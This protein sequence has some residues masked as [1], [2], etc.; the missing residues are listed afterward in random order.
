MM[1]HPRWEL[2]HHI[3]NSCHFESGRCTSQKKH[4]TGFEV[5]QATGGMCV[6][7]GHDAFSFA[8]L[9]LKANTLWN[10]KGGLPNAL[11]LFT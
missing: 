5:L 1:N 8:C 7:C 3:N 10:L 6:L 11:F 2:V 4:I 9:L